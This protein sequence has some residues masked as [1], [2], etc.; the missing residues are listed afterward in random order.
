M[1]ENTEQQEVEHDT[2][3][4]KSL[5]EKLKEDTADLKGLLANRDKLLAEK[6]K[7]EAEAEKVRA[8]AEKEKLQKNG[9]YEKL[10]KAAEKEKLDAINKIKELETQA[11]QK[12][13][14]AQ[15]MS[16]ASQVK[17]RPES[18][19]I[20]SGEIYRQLEGLVDI[21]SGEVPE[22]ALKMVISEIETADKFKPLLMG[23][24]S[25][26]G[27]ASGSAKSS[28]AVQKLSDMTES[29]QI[30]LFRT[31]RDKYNELKRNETR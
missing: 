1:S 29:E 14:R 22:A 5:Y 12:E 6:K 16:I 7:V 23:N 19:E 26:G 27:G 31:D 25:S 11:V 13:L 17:G 2:T 18:M 4:Y 3:D 10:L 24:Q 9:E 15:A 21:D 28:G 30:K 8:A 20:L